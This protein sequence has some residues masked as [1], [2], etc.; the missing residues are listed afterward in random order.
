MMS[1]S[2]VLMI[3]RRLVV[4]VTIARPGADQGP[5]SCPDLHRDASAVQLAAKRGK[6]SGRR[7]RTRTI[8]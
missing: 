6:L 2:P 4:P 7:Y 1:V 8:H 5:R 3:S